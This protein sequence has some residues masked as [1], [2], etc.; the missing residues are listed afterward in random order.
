MSRIGAGKTTLFKLI[1][2]DSQPDSSDMFLLAV[3]G[4][5]ALRRRRRRTRSRCWTVLEADK[6]RDALLR[7]ADTA[8]NIERIAE[9]QT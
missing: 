7:E 8:S 1:C 6:E 4:S 2:G 5:A 3:H 9:I